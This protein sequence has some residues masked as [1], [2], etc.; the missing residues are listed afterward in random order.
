MMTPMERANYNF[1]QVAR[2]MQPALETLGAAFAAAG[3]ASLQGM[4]RAIEKEKA[5]NP[6]FAR[7]MAALQKDNKSR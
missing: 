5:R 6:A 4:T 7:S 1:E 3:V 2:D